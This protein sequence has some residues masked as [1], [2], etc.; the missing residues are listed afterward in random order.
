MEQR[1]SFRGDLKQKII[2]TLLIVFTI[3]IIMF[4]YMLILPT[5]VFYIGSGIVASLFL[6]T[7][8]VR[9]KRKDTK[10]RR[11][12]EERRHKNQVA[13]LDNDDSEE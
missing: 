12:G 13:E 9:K 11:S 10:E 5:M 2:F 8:E 7:T 1:S 6:K 4:P 3:L